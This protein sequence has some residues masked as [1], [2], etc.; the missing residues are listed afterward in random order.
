MEAKII[1]EDNENK[2]AEVAGDFNYRKSE[3]KTIKPKN[4]DDA[5]TV[6]NCLRDKIPVIVNFEETPEEE[7]HR[8]MDFISGTTYAVE[9]KIRQVSQKVFLFAPNNITL[10]STSE[11][12]RAW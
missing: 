4:I 2:N 11:N 8:V 3:I 12:K 1:N 6:S 7:M 10:E 9:G 5:Q